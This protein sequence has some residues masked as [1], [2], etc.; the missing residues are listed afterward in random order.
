MSGNEAREYFKILKIT[1]LDG[2]DLD[3]DIVYYKGKKYF[4]DALKGIVE[5]LEED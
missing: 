3:G 4:V 1:Y 2:Y 5:S